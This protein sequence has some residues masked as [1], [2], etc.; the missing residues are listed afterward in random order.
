MIWLPCILRKLQ[1][2]PLTL[3]RGERHSTGT[4]GGGPLGIHRRATPKL[5]IPNNTDRNQRMVLRFEYGNL[6]LRKAI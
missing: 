4:D 5:G 1:Q 3:G 6:T 2:L